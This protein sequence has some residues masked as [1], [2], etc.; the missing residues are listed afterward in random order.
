M[1]QKKSNLSSVVAEHAQDAS[2]A[3]I[4]EV[5]PLVSEIE[6]TLKSLTTED[7]SPK[8]PGK[9]C[10]TPTPSPSPITS[11]SSPLILYPAAYHDIYSAVYN[12]SVW[13]TPNYERS[14]L[15]DSLQRQHRCS[16]GLMQKLAVLHT[17][18]ASV[19]S[20]N[21]TRKLT[22]KANALRAEIAKSHR[23]EQMILLRLQDMMQEGNH[24]PMAMG[25]RGQEGLHQQSPPSALYAAAA[26]A[27]TPYS[28][29]NDMMLPLNSPETEPISPLT[30]LPAG[31]Y[32][33][34]PAVPSPLFSPYWPGTQ[35]P[36]NGGTGINGLLYYRGLE[37]QPRG[38]PPPSR[39]MSLA[40]IGE[41]APRH[42]VNRSV[43][44]AAPTKTDNYT[45][46][47]RS[48]A[49]VFPLQGK[50]KRMS[51]PGS[52]TIWKGKRP[53]EQEENEQ[54]SPRA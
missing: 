13:E 8:Q 29:W 34:P 31:L 24:G 16:Q 20:R 38:V 10:K 11:S 9:A 45:G 22:K 50:D 27:W 28:V 25:S 39:R 52:Q 1:A 42:G 51:M 19:H 43:V 44:I 26:V 36:I 4:T 6:K 33:P 12:P 37:F 23:Q 53:E 21:E 32:H 14:Y 30:S 2:T 15:L 41:H 18:L 35:Y 5:P 47:R 17:S 40:D 46:R 48:Y 3:T 54:D 49:D 7:K